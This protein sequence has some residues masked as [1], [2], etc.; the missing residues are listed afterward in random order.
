M[1]LPPS[2]ERRTAE[3]AR[4]T[5]DER[6]HTLFNHAPDGILIADREGRYIDANLSVCR[7][8]GYSREELMGIDASGIVAGSEV[9]H[10]VPALRAIS[11]A[12]YHR[13]WEFRRKDGS[14]FFADVMATAMPDGNLLAMIRDLTARKDAERA[15]V[16]AEQR[17]RFALESAQIGIWDLDSVTG[18]LKW[19]SVLEQ[20]YGLAPGTFEGTFDAFI[21]RVHPDDREA[22]LAV[23]NDATR[24]G[25]DFVVNYRIMRPDGAVRSLSGAGRMIVDH[26][27]HPVRAIGR[28]WD[29]AKC[30]SMAPDTAP[31][32]GS[33]SNRFSRPVC[34]PP[35]SPSSPRRDL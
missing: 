2:T 31:R 14:T 20:Q 11:Q 8:L 7:M 1:R 17:M 3:R 22:V 29:A 4:Q 34:G 35:H 26:A 6:Y 16:I 24:N 33:T 23:I 15:A 18:V 32:T 10:I 9:E 28:F 19:S 30:C 13:E 12:P 27:G 21:D 5:S 25:T